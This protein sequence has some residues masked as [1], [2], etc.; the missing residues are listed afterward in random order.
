MTGG[1]LERFSWDNVIIA[2]II[3][4]IVLSVMLLAAL[5][6]HVTLRILAPKAGYFEALT[7]L[8]YGLFILASG[9]LISAFIGL[10][11][12]YGAMS[13]LLLGLL[14]GII[15]V[16]TFIMSHA[17]MIRMGMAL[18]KTDLLTTLVAFWIV[19][20]AIFLAGYFVVAKYFLAKAMMA[21]TTGMGSS[22]MNI[23]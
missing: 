14:S 3:F 23:Y 16:F 5:L 17:V 18:F 20:T 9:Y 8:S 2:A 11:S 22:G 15:L 7:T 21:Y 12:A 10:I 1:S 6:M 19:Y 13:T 4:I